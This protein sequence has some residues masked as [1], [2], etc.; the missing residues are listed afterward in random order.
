MCVYV[1]KKSKNMLFYDCRHCKL[2]EKH[3]SSNLIAVKASEFDIILIFMIH[4][5]NGG[6]FAIKGGIK[7][8]ISPK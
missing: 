1:Q 7:C 6:I 8:N 5:E 2:T 4:S 3:F